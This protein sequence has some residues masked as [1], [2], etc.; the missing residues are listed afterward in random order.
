M[1]FDS[2]LHLSPRSIASDD[3]VFPDVARK[4]VVK[5][6]TVVKK[7]GEISRVKTIGTKTAELSRST[8]PNAG[9]KKAKLGPKELLE[10]AA[11]R[12]TVTRTTSVK[13]V[14]K[15]VVK[16]VAKKV[17]KEVAKKV[18]KKVAKKVVTKAAKEVVKKVVKKDPKEAVSKIVEEAVKKVIKARKAP[19]ESSPPKKSWAT[20]KVLKQLRQKIA[21]SDLIFANAQSVDLVYLLC[22]SV[23]INTITITPLSSLPVTMSIVHLLKASNE[24]NRSTHQSDIIVTS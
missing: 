6:V 2:C 11:L 17:V 10:A 16:E 20:V 5:T 8:I 15:K 9:G 14:A 22:R 7:S 21:N 3:N 13:E 4:V 18:V 23:Q 1:K 24:M 12:K 19:S